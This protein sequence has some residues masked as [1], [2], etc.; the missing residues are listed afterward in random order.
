MDST[1]Q[2]K[3]FTT[4]RETIEARR[5]AATTARHAAAYRRMARFLAARADRVAQQDQS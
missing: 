3:V 1:D 4:L 2:E 5:Q